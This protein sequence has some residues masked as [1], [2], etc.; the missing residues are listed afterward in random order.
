MWAL[1]N[2][3]AF[4]PF[5]IAGL[6][7]LILLIVEMIGFF[8][9]GLSGM[10]D[11]LLPDSLVNADFDGNFSGAADTDTGVN[12]DGG[13][14][15]LGLK[16]LDWLYVGRIPTMI[17]LILFITSF[18]IIGFIIQQLAFTVLGKFISPW[19][20]SLDALVI[21][22]PLLRMLALVLYPILPKDETTAVSGD[23]LVGRQA[24]II[25]GQAS[26]G[27]PAQAKLTDQHGQM[28]YVMVEPDPTH[29]SSQLLVTET[30]VSA[31]VHIGKITENKNLIDSSLK[32]ST[33]TAD[34]A[35]IIT[36]K[37][38]E[39]YLVKKL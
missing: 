27:Q 2:T 16:A 30:S 17:L 37:I 14:L 3:P 15:S 18:C 32:P 25:L 21:S 9:G 36:Q 11:S 20:A 13:S 29:Y 10:L 24:R 7:L 4:A 39:R 31:S 35:L 38:G 22:F 28:H 33:I 6:V 12:I 19:L 8:F 23:S 1:I 34:D 5:I 26:I